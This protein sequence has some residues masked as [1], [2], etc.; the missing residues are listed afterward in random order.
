MYVYD[1]ST[2]L[3]PFM[4]FTV[5][6]CYYFQSSCTW[7]GQDALGTST[8]NFILKSMSTRNNS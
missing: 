8:S 3:T 7:D 1:L 6:I 2:Y 4:I 5:C